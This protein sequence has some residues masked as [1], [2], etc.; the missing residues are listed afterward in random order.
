[1]SILDNI[2][3]NSAADQVSSRIKNQTKQTFQNMVNAFNEGS[4]TFWQN[5]RG[6]TPTQIA[7]A[8]GT[9]GKEIFQLHYKLGELIA[10]IKP[11]AINEGLSL[12]GSFSYSEDNR[13]IINDPQPSVN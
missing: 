13:I 12:I 10:S 5:P 4:K 2:G 11:E 1:M 9:D 3:E 6:L 7:E 8:L